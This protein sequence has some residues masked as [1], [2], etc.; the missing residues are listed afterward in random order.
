[1]NGPPVNGDDEGEVEEPESEVE[2]AAEALD[3]N[4]MRPLSRRHV[5][6]KRR[7]LALAPLERL[8][9]DELLLEMRKLKDV[10]FFAVLAGGD[11]RRGARRGARDPRARTRAR[12]DD[13]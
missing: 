1:M 2:E 12:R 6:P 4:K 7:R 10:R 9:L 11:G 8:E 5:G 3:P 13:G